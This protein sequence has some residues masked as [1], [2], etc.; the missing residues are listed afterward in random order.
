MICQELVLFF[1]N[2][3]RKNPDMYFTIHKF[4]IKKLLK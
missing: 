3:C 1:N 4:I 2:V